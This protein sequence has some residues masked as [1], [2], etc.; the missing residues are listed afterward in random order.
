[1]RAD[2][3]ITEVE[4]ECEFK[5]LRTPDRRVMLAF[6][7]TELRELTGRGSF[8]WAMRALRP[9]ISLQDGKADYLL[10]EDFGDN[11]VRGAGD[12]GDKWCCMLDDG[13]SEAPLDYVSPPQFFSMNLTASE[14]ADPSKYTI[15][16]S[17]DGRRYLWV[18]PTPDDSTH[19]INGLYIPTNWKLT[20]ADELPPVPGNAD[21][22]RYALL[23][24]I[25]ANYDS[26]YQNAFAQLALRAANQRRN[27][28]VPR[29]D[30]TMA[31]T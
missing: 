17:N 11:F 20:E 24:K 13:S 19:T 22:L 27:Q 18:N 8:D 31:R 5:G 21:V 14:E 12:D 30:S 25:S 16:G 15:I 23:R 9:A 6:L 1:M 28:F 29:L 4:M 2:E 3:I 10:P 26:A 7:S